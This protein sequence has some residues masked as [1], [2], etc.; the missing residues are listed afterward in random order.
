MLRWTKNIWRGNCRCPAPSFAPLGNQ[1]LPEPETTLTRAS[2]SWIYCIADHETD[3]SRYFRSVKSFSTWRLFLSVSVTSSPTRRPLVY[4]T[5]M[6]GPTDIVL[7]LEYV[8]MPVYPRPL[9][10]RE[11]N[12]P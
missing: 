10:S 2:N 3:H 9:E 1:T 8:A 11:A 4:Y 7:K 5:E 12:P 6:Q